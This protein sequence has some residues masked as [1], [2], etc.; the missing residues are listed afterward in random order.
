MLLFF[1]IEKRET[2][3]SLM[4]SKLRG[5]LHRER[6]HAPAPSECEIQLRKN[7]KQLH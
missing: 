7:E 2:L 4:E 3:I 6:K 5:K 1:L